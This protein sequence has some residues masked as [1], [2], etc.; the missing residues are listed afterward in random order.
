[1]TTDKH[2]DNKPPEMLRSSEQ[3]ANTDTA[4]H[5]KTSNEDYPTWPS[6]TMRVDDLT[7]FAA[8]SIPPQLREIFGDAVMDK[9]LTALERFELLLML[10]EDAQMVFVRFKIV[11]LEESRHGP[12]TTAAPAPPARSSN[13]VDGA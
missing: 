9:K 8:L 11:P 3:P 1:M 12:L 13:P 10:R 2:Q 6:Q 7:A 4:A 5:P